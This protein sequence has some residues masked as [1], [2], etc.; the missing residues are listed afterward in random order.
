MC[1][2][3][4]DWKEEIR[5]YCIDNESNFDNVEKMAKSWGK[6]DI[7]LLYIDKEKG[8]NGLIDDTPAPVVLWIKMGLDGR[9]LFEQTEHTDKYLKK[10]S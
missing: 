1:K 7:A 10:V 8:K 5:R 9:L 6:N 3:F 2:L 4:D